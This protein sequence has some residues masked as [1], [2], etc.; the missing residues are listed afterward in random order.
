MSH[1]HNI[2]P[3]EGVGP[4]GVSLTR[5]GS[6]HMEH[7]PY[8]A[9]V[10]RAGEGYTAILFTVDDEGPIGQPVRIDVATVEAALAVAIGHLQAHGDTERLVAALAKSVTVVDERPTAVPTLVA[11]LA[12]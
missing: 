7:G 5:D 4:I 2:N 9:I 1:D 12:A 8:I 6:F 11:R 3:A 10:R